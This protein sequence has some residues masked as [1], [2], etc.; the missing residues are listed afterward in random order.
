MCN[1]YVKLIGNENDLKK[2]K[3][4]FQLKFDITSRNGLKMLVFDGWV[5]NLIVQ[6]KRE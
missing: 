5:Y 4:L 6:I 1:G 3:E 2:F